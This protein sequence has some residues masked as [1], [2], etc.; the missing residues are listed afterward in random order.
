[1]LVRDVLDATR[2][3]A[4]EYAGLPEM[5]P[6]TE[7]DALQEAQLLDVWLD[8]ARSQVA[9]LFELRMSLQLREPNT[10]VLVAR[11]V[12]EL[13]WSAP[14]RPTSRTAWS[15]G[16]SEVDNREGLFRLNLGLWPAPGARLRMIAEAALFVA[17]DVPGLADVP[18]DYTGD[19][20]AVSG[21]LAS[22]DSPFVP[23]SAVFLDRIA[24]P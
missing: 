10:G 9:L 11:G 14:P 13:A 15:V 23:S 5:D 12:R 22:W 24:A 8:A 1:M 16:G 17:G 20:A 2:V 21:Q 19:E 7:G 6:L 18:P 3:S 4:R